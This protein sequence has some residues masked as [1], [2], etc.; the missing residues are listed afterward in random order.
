MWPLALAKARGVWPMLLVALMSAP[1]AMRSST[2]SIRPAWAALC[3]GVDSFFRHPGAVNINGRRRQNGVRRLIIMKH[4][5]DFSFFFKE[6]HSK[7]QISP[8]IMGHAGMLICHNYNTISRG[9]ASC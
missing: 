8:N 1:F 9:N 5:M 4:M 7:R 3:N 6:G 2:I